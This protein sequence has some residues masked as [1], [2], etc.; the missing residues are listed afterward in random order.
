MELLTTEQ[1]RQLI[2]NWNLADDIKP[3]V[4]IFSPVGTAT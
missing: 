3:V 4:K 2:E 1:R